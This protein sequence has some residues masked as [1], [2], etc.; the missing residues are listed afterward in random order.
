MAKTKVSFWLIPSEQDRSFFQDIIDSLAKEHNAPT[1]TPHV[2]IYSGEYIPDESLDELIEKATQ[3]VQPFSLRVDSISYTNEF[4]KT[5]FVQFQPHPILTQ[6]SETIHR[7]SLHPSDF[8]LNP[9]LSLI[10][11]HLSEEIKI[12]LANSIKLP[13][14]EVFFNEVRAIS[15]PNQTQNREDVENWKVITIKNLDIASLHDL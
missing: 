11:K 10:Y 3:R 13:K 2:T 4:T 8:T 12:D 9:H 5:V 6:I 7:N 15:T 14:S 1:F